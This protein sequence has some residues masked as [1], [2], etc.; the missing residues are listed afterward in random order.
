MLSAYD[1]RELEV[2]DREGVA[3]LGFSWTG[4][5]FSLIWESVDLR[6]KEGF[7]NIAATSAAIPVIE[8]RLEPLRKVAGRI[9]LGFIWASICALM[10][11]RLLADVS[12]ENN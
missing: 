12:E 3:G 10:V 5:S 6:S 1:L 11:C 2:S 7:P 8:N 4:A 9:A